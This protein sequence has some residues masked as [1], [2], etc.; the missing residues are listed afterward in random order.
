MKRI[1]NTE[2]WTDGTVKY[3]KNAQGDFAIYIE[4]TVEVTVEDNWTYSDRD[5][6]TLDEP[7]VLKPND[8]HDD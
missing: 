3:T 6:V 4:E 8:E 1:D 7:V 2:V 5:F